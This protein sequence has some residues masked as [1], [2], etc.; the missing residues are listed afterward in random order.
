MLG[1]PMP[2]VGLQGSR[3]MAG[4]AACLDFKAHPHMLQHACGFA[5]ANAGHNVAPSS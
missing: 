2:E 5:R 4:I 3:I 1:I